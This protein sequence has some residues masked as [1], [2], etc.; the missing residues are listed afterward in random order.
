MFQ[1]TEPAADRP[2]PPSS[3]TWEQ[4]VNIGGE[5]ANSEPA[6]RAAAVSVQGIANVRN[7]P[8]MAAAANKIAVV[9][10]SATRV[11][12][13]TAQ[14]RAITICA[15]VDGYLCVDESSAQAA[16]GMPLPADTPVTLQSAAEIWFASTG[17]GTV[18]FW[19]ELDLG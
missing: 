13:K 8:S 6:A 9:T 14:R 5:D 1:Q 16:S 18:G 4:D 7:V 3:Q 10:S 19:A 12:G 11:V 17:N 2:Y 15:D